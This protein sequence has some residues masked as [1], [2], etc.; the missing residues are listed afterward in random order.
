[1]KES[2]VIIEETDFPTESAFPPLPQSDMNVSPF[3]PPALELP[4][5]PR[6]GELIHSRYQ[7]ETVHAPRSSD[8]VLPVA[9]P[10]DAFKTGQKYVKGDKITACRMARAAS[11]V[12]AFAAENFMPPDVNATYRTQGTMSF[13][14]LGTKVT[15]S[16]IEIEEAFLRVIRTKPVG[17]AKFVPEEVDKADLKVVLQVFFD[18]LLGTL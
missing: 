6:E 15:K 4:P 9:F 1:L 7:D 2:A 12:V 8:D 18:Y 16:Q 10:E 5:P 17:D 11:E 3:P 13:V 14:M